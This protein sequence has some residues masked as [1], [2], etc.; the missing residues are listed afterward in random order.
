MATYVLGDPHLSFG[1]SKPMDVFGGK[2]EGYT[3][4]LQVSL[5]NLK[6]EDTLVL[7]GDISWAMTL[8]EFL[9]DIQFIRNSCK[10]KIVL[11][12][13]NH[14]YWW[15]TVG[16]MNSFLVQNGL[17]NIEFLHNNSVESDDFILCGTRGWF[18]DLNHPSEADNQKVSQRELLRLEASLV[19]GSKNYE[20]EIIV[21]LH[22]PP[23]YDGYICREILEI[24]KKY[25]IKRCYYGHIHGSGIRFAF[26]GLYEG[27]RFQLISGDAID[28]NPVKIIPKE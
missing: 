23:V 19:S 25:S 3:N 8:P 17:S 20:K 12:K 4:K 10:A 6:A 1:S 21:F 28:F 11:L 26:N 7:A 2:W 15:T 14:D 16:K 27:I 5:G 9:P 18:I 22:Y 24:L 13:G